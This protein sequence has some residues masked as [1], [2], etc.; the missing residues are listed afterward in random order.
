MAKVIIL[1]GKIASGKTTYA[2]KLKKKQNAVILSY[3]DLMLTL[4]DGCLGDRHNETV[5]RISQY[6]FPLAQNIVSLGIDAILDFG[7]WRKTERE[8]AREYFESRR[9]PSELHYITVP[10]HRRLSQLESRNQSLKDSTERVY[11]ID[12]ELCERLDQNFEEPTQ[13]EID[14]IIEPNEK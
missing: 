10:E 12:S 9:I 6:F 3:D 5:N 14:L 13:N 8:D 7:F 11:L 1:C 4:Y 2:N